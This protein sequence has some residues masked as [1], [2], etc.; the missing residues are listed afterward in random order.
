MKLDK[1]NDFLSKWARAVSAYGTPIDFVAGAGAKT[2]EY[3]FDSPLE[4][5][6]LCSPNNALR[7]ELMEK[8]KAEAAARKASGAEER[9]PNDG[10]ASCFLC[11]NVGQAQVASFDKSIPD[12]VVY[13][14]GKYLILP[15]RYPALIGHS[16]FVPK[17]HDS[18]DG[19][20]VPTTIEEAGKK[21]QVY[22]PKAGKTAG[23]L[24]SPD[25][26][27]A[28]VQACDEHNLVGL[29]NHVRDGMSIPGHKHFHLY[30]EDFDLFACS[31][32][33]HFIGRG[34]RASTPPALIAESFVDTD[35]G[36]QVKKVRHTPFDT[37][38]VIL[39]KSVLDP[40]ISSYPIKEGRDKGIETVANILQKMELAN[41]VFTLAYNQGILL[42]SPRKNIP[43]GERIQI[44][45]GVPLHFFGSE[46]EMQDT[47]KKHVPLKSD[48]DCSKSDYDW[49]R[50][51]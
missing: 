44:G 49:A 35:Y 3:Q 24:T 5:R 11:D 32:I 25:Y 21:R 41:E 22:I 51:M 37:L 48:Y 9:W 46:E 23:D 43:A 6:I 33:R 15:N 45:S 18:P 4:V 14:R 12:N 38:A 34:D 30:P 8:Q 40:D 28:S 27:D 50:F 42:V 39:Y 31:P 2:A 36:E 10:N 7:R 26:L 20:I 16:L 1:W 47:I 13:E 19:R 17:S 29:N